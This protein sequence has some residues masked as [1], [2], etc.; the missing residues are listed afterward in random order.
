MIA[1]PLLVVAGGAWFWLAGGRYESTDDAYVQS[2]RTAISANIAGRVVDVAVRDNQRVQ[3]GDV[4]FRID[5]APFRIAVEEASAQLAS[6]RLQVA[7]LKANYRQR[8]ADLAAADA[9]LGF[10][11]READ[12]QQRL[13]A[14]GIA[15]QTQV[16]N[17]THALDEARAQHAAAEQQ[18]AAVVASLGGNAAI[19][20]D[21]HPL[22]QKA[23][24]ELDRAKLNLGYTVV[25]APSAGIVT[26]V[27]ALQ[28]GS[29]VNAAQ[30]LFALVS[31]NDLWVAANF[32]ED[33]LAHMRVGQRATVKLDSYPGHVFD[34]RVASLSPGTGSQFS[35]L[36][37]E[38]ATGNWVKVVQRLPVRIELD[39]LDPHYPLHAGLSA[40]VAVDTRRERHLFGAAT[41][42]EPPPASGPGAAPA[43]PIR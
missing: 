3:K 7:T 9:T 34:G 6:A 17:A 14:S 13:L 8:Q 42:L 33:Q 20:A 24:A 2:A 22:V 12:R 21:A 1:G 32:K 5:D 29:Y 28:P 15:S 26:R 30:P 11:Q 38:N 36:P 10:R 27:D 23:Q 35:A 43:A 39:Q 31:G 16:D 19:A 37:A 41:A 18:I 4:L 40:D 25:A